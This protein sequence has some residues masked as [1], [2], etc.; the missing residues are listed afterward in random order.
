MRAGAARALAAAAVAAL[1]L[2][3]CKSE[4]SSGGRLERSSDAPAVV[5]VE[6]SAQ[7]DLAAIKETEPNDA[8]D[9]AMAVELP[10]AV[11]GVLSSS[12]DTDLY[13]FVAPQS[14][15]LVVR[16]D[17]LEGIDTMV[18]ILDVEGEV[19]VTS[20][21]G[22]KGTSEG[23]PN[24]P[25]VKG[26]KVVVAVKE[27]VKKA[28]RE[29]PEPARAGDSPPYRLELSM[30]E[31]SPDDLERE[32]NDEP[33]EA[34]EI[35]L[36]DRPTGY[37]GW[38]GD[39]DVWKLSLQ[40][41]GEDNLIDLSI[42]GLDGVTLI[43]TLR[44]A[45]GK[46]VLVREGR[47]SSPVYVRGLSPP[48][49]GHLLAALSAKRSH[50]AQRYRIQFATRLR[51]DGDEVEPNDKAEGATELEGEAS[52]GSA[53]GQLSP[54]DVDHWL[55]PATAGRIGM[56]VTVAGPTGVELAIEASAG[57]KALGSAVSGASNLAEVIGVAL[58]Q[59]ARVLVKVTGKGAIAEPA[60]YE[61]RWSSGPIAAPSPEPDLGDFAP[62]PGDQLE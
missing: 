32:P 58:E 56:T 9:K 35:L 23:M 26:Q 53:R 16:V 34:R 1:L 46:A 33:D 30:L 48:T 6:G 25:V 19:V 41:F 13:S 11:A 17:G 14:G 40:G 47:K 5:T 42:E 8:A 31:G 22:P 2:A 49:S 61:L 20:D 21:R 54:G 18:E 52:G 62:D 50:E 55:L 44:D 45:D 7:L 36:G 10:V 27:F 28:L 60:S 15:Q 38:S 39:V 59:G 24:F 51:G 3:S 12:N 37:I 4:S 29:K 43:L 57:G